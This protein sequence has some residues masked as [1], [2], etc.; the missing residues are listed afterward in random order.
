MH[1]QADRALIPARTPAVRHLTVTITAPGRQTPERERPAA[2]VALV[3][4]RSG[5]MD[6]QKIAMARAAVAHAI[7]LLT[8]RD[9]LALVVYDDRIDTLLDASPA[10][11]ETKAKALQRLAKIDARGS[12]DLGG[13]LFKGAELL[14]ESGLARVL[15]LTDGLANQGIVELDQLAKAAA[16][17][18]ADGITTSTFGV[19]ADFD[20]ELL[21][22]LAIEGGGHFYFIETAAQIPDFLTSE[23][24]ETL[25]IVARDAVFDLTCGSYVDATVLNGFPVETTPGRVRVKLGD[26]IADQEITLAIAVSCAPQPLESTAFVDCRVTDRDGALFQEPMRMAWRAADLRENE[27]Q[28]VN[29]EVLVT[30]AD[31]LAQRARATALAANRRGEF[32]DARR[33]IRDIVEHLLGLAPG[34]RKIIEIIDGL[35]RDEL[36]LGDGLDS[37]TR[38]AMHFAS[39]TS[40]Y[41]RDVGGKA[42]RS[43]PPKS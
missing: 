19:G 10:T 16:K 9:R 42:R 12:T 26:L 38:K 7:K 8:T 21:S 15:L 34:N 33:V 35:R 29:Q 36:A 28:P 11:Q 24:G 41:S 37:M 5:S 43:A 20:E 22:R 40:A 31:V 2:N 39:Y 1:I 25:E 17:F 30:V 32:E 13:G 18:R 14:A 23:L 27:R 3:L 6:G 4:D